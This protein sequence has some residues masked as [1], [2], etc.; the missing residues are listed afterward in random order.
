LGLRRPDERGDG[1]LGC[2]VRPKP[3]CGM[4]ISSDLLPLFTG[5]MQRHG[6]AALDPAELER[7]VWRAPRS[8][9]SPGSSTYRRGSGPASGRI[10]ATE[11]RDPRIAATEPAGPAADA[12]E[13]AQQV[14]DAG[15]VSNVSGRRACGVCSGRKP[16]P[17]RVGGITGNHAHAVERRRQNRPTASGRPQPLPCGTRVITTRCAKPLHGG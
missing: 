13:S 7:L 10:R 5:E 6:G 4:L 14:G 9:E 11:P 12:G 3:P 17:I 15:P 16:T 1:D 2:V 8:W